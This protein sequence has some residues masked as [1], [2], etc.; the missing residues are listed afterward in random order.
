MSRSSS[1]RAEVAEAVGEFG[2]VRE[3]L[4]VM[5]QEQ[6]LECRRV[7]HQT[8]HAEL[9]EPAHR[10]LELV[11]V[12]VEANAATVDVEAVNPGQRSEAIGRVQDLGNDRRSRHSAQLVE[13]PALLRPAETND[14]HA[15][16][17]RL[18]LREDVARQQDGAT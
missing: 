5:A 7:A 18:D 17:Q 11:V 2:L 1:S 15:V 3:L 6:L 9:G 16:T 13:G 14:A 12:D 10:A 4:A 8:S